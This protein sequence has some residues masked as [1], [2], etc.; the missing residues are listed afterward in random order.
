MGQAYAMDGACD[1]GVACGQVWDHVAGCGAC[2]RVWGYVV[3]G[4]AYGMDRD[5]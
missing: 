5:M 3:G 4:Q 2:G 1:R